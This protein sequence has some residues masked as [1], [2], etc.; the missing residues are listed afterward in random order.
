M[1][2]VLPIIVLIAACAGTEKSSA[3]ESGATVPSD[4]ATSELDLSHLIYVDVHPA[5]LLDADSNIIVLP[6]TV[7]PFSPEG[8]LNVGSIEL[9]SPTTIDG[10]VTADII[11]PQAA[12]AQ[13]PFAYGPISAKVM[14]LHNDGR[15][16]QNYISETDENGFFESLLVA[17]RYDIYVVPDDPMVPVISLHEPI[18]ASGATVDAAIEQGA[19]IWGLVQY[20]SLPS[21]DPFRVHVIDGN[22]VRSATA[23]TDEDGFYMI[24]VLPEEGPFTVICEGRDDGRDPLLTSQT[25]DPF[26]E[27]TDDTGLESQFVGVQVD[28]DYPTYR[29]GL[30]SGRVLDD[31]GAPVGDVEVRFT[32]TKLTGYETL[33]ESLQ[34]TRVTDPTGN[35]DMSVPAGDYAVEYM[36]EGARSPRLAQA[37]VAGA[38]Q[39]GSIVLD[40]LLPVTGTVRDASGTRIG[41]ASVSCVEVGFGGREWKTFADDNGIYALDLPN[42]NV[43]CTITPPD[44]RAHA[45]TRQDLDG[46]AIVGDLDLVVSEGTLGRGTVAFDGQPEAFAV[47]EFRDGNGRLLGS[48]VT[49]DEGDFRMQIDLAPAETGSTSTL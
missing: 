8:G 48:T 20:P 10:N 3:P 35:F 34:I 12:G 47:V 4:S 28:F 22:G 6:Q 14:V 49:D 18:A 44:T 38:T 2:R 27:L 5:N 39:F 32:S 30:A 9:A 26:E 43:T 25:I 13:L 46:S 41:S 21:N 15:S 1:W 11:T 17:D 29:L 23:L 7:G 45:L 36:P 37:T 42:T 33:D 24:R 31:T 19:A 40:P 16:V